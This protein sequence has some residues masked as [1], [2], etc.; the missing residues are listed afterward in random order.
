MPKV[1]KTSLVQQAYSQKQENIK[2]I[3]CSIVGGF[4]ECK[5]NEKVLILNPKR[6]KVGI[7]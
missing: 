2:V 5:N 3:K 6:K 1:R 4:N 7:V